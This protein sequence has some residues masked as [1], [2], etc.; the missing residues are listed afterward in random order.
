MKYLKQK[1]SFFRMRHLFI[2]FFL[3]SVVITSVAQSPTLNLALHL[4]GKDNN[5]RTGIRIL[6]APWTLETWI[7][8]DDK[9]WKDQEIIFGGGEYSQ[10]NITDYLPLVIEKE[11]FTVLRQT[12]GRKMYWMINGII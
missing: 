8:G 10:L 2:F 4:D 9:S 5:V 1:E 3:Y 11:N 6:N 12:Y 7:K